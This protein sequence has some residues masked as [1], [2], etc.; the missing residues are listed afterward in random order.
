MAVH[1]AMVDRMDREIGRILDTP[2]KA[3]TPDDTL[4]LFLSDNGASAEES[5][6]RGDGH[7]PHAE[8]RHR[9]DVPEHRAGAQQPVQHPLP[10]AQDVGPRGRHSH[11]ARGALAEGHC[12]EGRSAAHAGA[13]D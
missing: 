4:V 12:G 5:M 1:A 3:G 10:P 9:G 13:C 6:V 8:R 2:K 7:H 11:P